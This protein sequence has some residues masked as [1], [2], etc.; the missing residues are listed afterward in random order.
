MTGRVE[1]QNRVCTMSDGVKVAYA[2]HGYGPPLV[3][4]ANWFTHLERDWQSAVWRHWLTDLAKTRTIVRYDERGCGLSDRD[5]FEYS[6]ETWLAELEAVVDEAGLGRFALLGLSQGGALAMAYAARHPERVSHLVLCGAYA[7]GTLKRP[8][9][10]EE[11]E[12]AALRQ[13][14]MRV[15]W[16]R[17]DPVFRRVFTTQFLPGG[18]EEQMAWFDEV[19]R[20]ST[21]PENAARIQAA[22][23]EIDVTALAGQVTAATLVLHARGDAVVPFEQ[24]RLL[25]TLIPGA[26]FIP[27]ES[28][29]HVLLADEPAWSVFLDEV[30]AFLGAAEPAAATEF[31]LSGR[32]REVLELVATGCSNEEIARRLF[33]SVRTVE[34]HLSNVYAKLGL[35]GKAARAAAAARF[36]Q[37]RQLA[38]P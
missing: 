22:R 10:P 2:T 38:S 17:P 31:D 20:F 30:R 29:N 1:Q 36:A 25:A 21:S 35:S 27:L 13:S 15:G 9:T 26:R 5:A 4:A 32:E 18:T 28:R 3:K 12:E 23:Y 6:F 16:G 19:Q 37:Q 7:L 11:R 8:T 24:G 34:R 14:L 33:L